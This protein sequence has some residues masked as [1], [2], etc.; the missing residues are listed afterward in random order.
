MKPIEMKKQSKTIT[1]FEHDSLKIDNCF[2][3]AHLAILQRFYGE[4]GV[5]YYNLIHNGV[6]FCEYVGV[7]QIGDLTIE[8]LP[9]ADKNESH[10][11]WQKLLIGM[12]Q[13]VGAFNIHAPSTATLNIRPNFILDLYFELF[14]KELEQLLHKGLIKK[15]RRKEG[16]KTAL[17]GS[18][19]F[20]KQL[21]HNIIHQERFYVRHSTYDKNHLIHQLLYK[22]LLLLKRINTNIQ[23]NSR[24]G[25]LTLDFPKQAD[26]KV[27]DAVFNKLEFNRKNESYKNVLQIAHL[28]LLNYHPDLVTG[29]QHVLAL[30]FDMNLLW[31]RFVYVSL[32]KLASKDMKVLGQN[33]TF[34]WTSTSGNR[35]S[36]RPDI[37]IE[38]DNG[39]K[40]VVDTKWKNIGTNNPS[41][42]DLRQLYVYHQYFQAT[43]VMLVYPGNTS[44]T[45]GKYYPAND[46]E[47]EDKICRII[48]IPIPDNNINIYSWQEEIAKK[49]FS[50]GIDSNV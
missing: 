15:Y 39:T 21:Q 37:V 22:T 4:K 1:L 45:S 47:K 10:S 27:S 13:A 48:S 19:H 11:K 33:S 12:L 20:S 2:T 43:E 6:K 44:E 50:R 31:E 40:L 3:A 17:K 23:L 8:I 7:L 25:R 46:K 32:R 24:I 34:F 26:V 41:I 16:N 28:L 49:I 18:L 5:P 29:N 30:M 14:I 35:S 9:K 36:I 38:N 42:Q